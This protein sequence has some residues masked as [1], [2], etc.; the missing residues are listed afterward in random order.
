MKTVSSATS[1]LDLNHLRA[2]I[3]FSSHEL[4]Q[5]QLLCARPTIL[6]RLVPK[7]LSFLKFIWIGVNSEI[8]CLVW[9]NGE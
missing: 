7:K 8:I 6:R 1:T 5:T 4:A 3:I 9:Q 2:N